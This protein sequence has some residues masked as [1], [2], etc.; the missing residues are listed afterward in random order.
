MEFVLDTNSRASELCSA[1]HTKNLIGIFATD[2]IAEEFQRIC[3]EIK[4]L[5]GHQEPYEADWPAERMGQNFLV[6]TP[7]AK[8]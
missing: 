4:C 2:V 6:L 3:K 8:L 7:W 5:S 1:I